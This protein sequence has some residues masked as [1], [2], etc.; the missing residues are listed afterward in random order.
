[1][2]S[3]TAENLI[4]I[5]QNILDEAPGPQRSRLLAGRVGFWVSQ[6]PSGWG[7]DSIKFLRNLNWSSMEFWKKNP[8]GS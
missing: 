4:S 8:V 5:I 2:V 7:Q 1:M 6:C 3:E